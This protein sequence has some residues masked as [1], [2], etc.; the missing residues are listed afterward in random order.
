MK[1]VLLGL[2]IKLL[3]LE[4]TAPILGAEAATSVITD[5]RSSI[6]VVPSRLAHRSAA[7]ELARQQAVELLGASALLKHTQK[8][9]FTTYAKLH[10]VADS[11]VIDRFSGLDFTERHKFTRVLELAGKPLG[12]ITCS[13]VREPSLEAIERQAAAWGR[14]FNPAVRTVIIA[15]YPDL[16]RMDAECCEYAAIDAVVVDRAYQQRGYGTQLVQAAEREI[17]KHWPELPTV[18]VDL[19][20][21]N[22][23]AWRLFCKTAGFREASAQPGMVKM[24]GKLRLEKALS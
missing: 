10:E 19:E 22:F 4:N 6:V 5:S 8:D 15:S 24:T 12:W 14:P 23:K 18:S 13:R 1:K 16:K 9:G 3:I 2:L 11:L 7:R 21:T 17:K 20:E